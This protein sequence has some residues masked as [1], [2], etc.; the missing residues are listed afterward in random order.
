MQEIVEA[1]GALQRVGE[2]RAQL[3]ALAGVGRVEARWHGEAELGQRRREERE[4]IERALEPIAQL[5]QL[6]AARAQRVVERLGQS[7]TASAWGMK[8]KADPLGVAFINGT[9]ARIR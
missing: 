9:A 3:Q 7:K 5:A 1:R 4:P 6:A 2:E 8:V